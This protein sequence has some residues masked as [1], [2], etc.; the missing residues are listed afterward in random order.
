MEASIKGKTQ[1]TLSISIDDLLPLIIRAI[2]EDIESL[3]GEE[4]HYTGDA[5]VLTFNVIRNNEQ[6]RRCQCKNCVSN[7]KK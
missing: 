2:Q 3:D 4:I 5:D 1:Q 7:R 6:K